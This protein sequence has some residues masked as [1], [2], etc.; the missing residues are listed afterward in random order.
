VKNN[1][2]KLCKYY[3]APM[4]LLTSIT[5]VGTD[6]MRIVGHTFLRKIPSME[7]V[8]NNKRKKGRREQSA[9]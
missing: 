1:A 3:I 4:K 5:L 2:T 9:Q 8:H 6:H 7:D